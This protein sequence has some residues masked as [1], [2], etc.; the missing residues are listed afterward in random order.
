MPPSPTDQIY[1]P[2]GWP[3]TPLP[4][5]VSVEDLPISDPHCTNDTCRAFREGFAE[6]QKVTPLLGLLEYGKWTVWF[7]SFWILLFTAIYVYHQ[8][9]DRVPRRNERSRKISPSWRDKLVALFRFCTYRRPDNWLTRSIGLRQVSYGVLMLLAFAT[10]FFTILP[11]PQRPYLRA[12]FRYGSPPLSVRCAFIISALTPLTVALA[13]K[14]NVITWMTGV[15]YEKFNVYHRYVAYVIFIFATIH[16]VPHFVSPVRDGGWSMLNSLY[17]NERRELSGT[18]LYFAT[19]GLAFFSIPLVRKRFYE[20]F[21]YLHIFLAVAYIGLFWWHIWGEYMSPNYLYATLAVLFFSNILRLVQRHRNLRYVANMNGWT[22]TI[23][24]LSGNMTR[25]AVSVPTSMKWKP[26]QHAF[27]RMPSLSWIG[28]HPFT[29]AN[30]PSAALERNSHEMIFLVRRQKGFTKKLFE[31]DK[32]TPE[33]TGRTSPPFFNFD[34]EKG[35]AISVTGEKTKHRHDTECIENT[36]TITEQE[37]ESPLSPLSQ[38]S[39]PI[40]SPPKPQRQRRSS[41]SSFPLRDEITTHKL[42]T[43]A[44]K[45][46]VSSPLRTIIDGPY[47]THRRPIHKLFDTVICIAG[48]SGITA[49]M[50]HILSLTTHLR[51]QQKDKILATRRIH[52]IWVIRDSEWVKWIE[53]GLTEA[54]K[55]IQN[56]PNPNNASFTVDIFITRERALAESASTSEDELSPCVSPVDPTG[57][58]RRGS[59]P[60]SDKVFEALGVSENGEVDRLPE[61]PRPVL[62]RLNGGIGL[63]D[64]EVHFGVESGSG[65]GSEKGEESAKRGVSVA[66]HYCRPVVADVVEGYVSGDRAIVLGCGPPSLSADLANTVARLQNR[67]LRGEMRELK[68]EIET[69]GW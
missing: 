51:N 11:W 20:A 6:D 33:D 31:T 5:G 28:N 13:G 58:G 48:G 36:I 29:I 37:V 60:F 34:F 54:V 40:I 50:P 7:Y 43:I 12:L 3:S 61:K 56:H 32:G 4:T 22:T 39:F 30:I 19:F 27:L 35:K 1:A 49:S 62:R 67:V 26:G 21:K 42:H 24:H 25:V 44:C 10:I 14:V 23:T 15:G 69:F 68:L 9:Q 65:S 8:V 66:M 46:G 45:S 2:P 63:F 57:R 52:L 18:P 64:E 47:G 53:E 17:A 59:L 16:T 38:S 55:N 41:S